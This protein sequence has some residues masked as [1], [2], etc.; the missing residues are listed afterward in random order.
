MS[1]RS[2]NILPSPLHLRPSRKV[3][4]EAQ[5]TATF[6]KTG[7]WGDALFSHD[8]AAGKMTADPATADCGHSCHVAVKSKDYIF[9]PY[10]KR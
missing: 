8:V 6:P 10:Q 9:H 2:I 1:P 7:G 4:H 5:G 3:V